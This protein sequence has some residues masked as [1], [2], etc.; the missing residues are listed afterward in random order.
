MRV[1]PSNQYQLVKHETSSQIQLASPKEQVSCGCTSFTYFNC[2]S[3]VENATSPP[4]AALLDDS[5]TSSETSTTDSGKESVADDVVH[6]A[7]QE[8]CIESSMKKPL[9]DCFIPAVKDNT[10][11]LSI[12]SP[13]STAGFAKARRVQWTDACG[14]ELFE[15]KEFQLSEGDLSDD[16]F[17][18]GGDKCNCVIL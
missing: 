13:S 5:E 10:V 16:D 6:E 4:D 8:I 15:I 9:A 12:E 1:S 14:K 3:T 18:H 2:A 11:N 17:G 7:E